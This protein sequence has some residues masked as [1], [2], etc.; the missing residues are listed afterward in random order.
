[1]KDAYQFA[2]GGADLR[3]YTVEL[4]RRGFDIVSMARRF[5]FIVSPPRP[6]EK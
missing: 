2:G 6:P 5:T 3:K 4:T 1:V